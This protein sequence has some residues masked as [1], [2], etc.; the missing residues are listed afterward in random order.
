MNNFCHYK[1]IPALLNKKAS[2]CTLCSTR[3][4]SIYKNLLSQSKYLCLL[5]IVYPDCSFSLNKH[6]YRYK[7]I[8]FFLHCKD[9]HI[10]ALKC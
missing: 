5:N 1:I 10:F 9:R 6:L 3:R 8:M 2:Y 4:T 7:A